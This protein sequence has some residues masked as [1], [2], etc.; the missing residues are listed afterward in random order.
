MKPMFDKGPVP[1]LYKELLQ[2]TRGR[3][4]SLKRAKI[5]RPHDP[6]LTPL[7]LYPEEWKTDV[8]TKIHV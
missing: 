7:D 8:R 6:A 2:L 5:E 4:L 3:Q 1:R